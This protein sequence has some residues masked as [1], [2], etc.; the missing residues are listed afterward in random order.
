MPRKGYTPRKELLPD[1]KFNSILVSRFINALMGRGKKSLAEG[2]MYEAV[3]DDGAA[4]GP[5][6]H[7]PCSSRPSATSS[8]WWR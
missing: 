1:P 8:R 3:A 2:I 5:G 7:R 6:R 4:D